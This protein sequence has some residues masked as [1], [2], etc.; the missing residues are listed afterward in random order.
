MNAPLRVRIRE[1]CRGGREQ[2]KWNQIQEQDFKDREQYLGQSTKVGLMGK[3]GRYYVHDWYS[4]KRERPEDL[5]DELDTVKAYEEQLM[6]EALG[7]KPK[8]LMLS[9][10]QLTEEEV[11]ELLKRDEDKS[12][13]KK[14][15][16]PMGPQK[17]I[18]KN[19]YGEEIAASNEDFVAIAAREAP[20]KGLGFAIHRT[21]KLEEIKAQTF[22][23]SSQL[24]G[25]S[26][27]SSSS[28]S[29]VEAKSEVKEEVKTE[30]KDEVKREDDDM[31]SIVDGVVDVRMK[32]LG[33]VKLEPSAKRS[34]SEKKD[35]KR[36]KEEK[37]IKKMEKKIKKAAKKEKKAAKRA[38]KAR[39]SV[40]A[41]NSSSSSASS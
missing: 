33:E 22:G 15:M 6:Q 36:K 2:F 9:K 20:I 39:G 25:S 8:K 11:Q 30:I 38:K 10:K 31:A 18:V 5:K 1:G 32:D 3:F 21:S 37:R 24:A 29:K 23:T 28:S 40:E 19:E 35:K 34:K 41:S 14:G 17:K 27:L 16:T 13:D 26:G 12:E 4:R 7:L